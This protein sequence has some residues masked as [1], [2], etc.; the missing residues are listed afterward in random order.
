[1]QHAEWMAE[2]RRQADARGEYSF[3]LDLGAANIDERRLARPEC[4]ISR[5]P[6][7]QGLRRSRPPVP[8]RS[9]ELNPEAS[10]REA[11]LLH[12]SVPSCTV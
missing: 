7:N 4:A 2:Q 5:C 11:G 6:A 12:F 3:T 1:V 9:P 10:K 8:V